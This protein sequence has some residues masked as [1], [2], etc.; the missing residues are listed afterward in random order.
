MSS[1]EEP[2][3]DPECGHDAVLYLLCGRVAAGKSTLAKSLARRHNAVLIG[4]DYCLSLLYSDAIR[5]FQDYIAYSQRLRKLISPHCVE[6]L[7]RGINVVL[8]FP[9]NTPKC[10]QWLKHIVEQAKARH[11]LH[12]V[13]TPKEQC[14]QQL[15]QRI[16]EQGDNASPIGL[17][18]F[19]RIN[20]YFVPPDVAEGFNVEIKR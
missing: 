1:L 4:E 17:K 6:L 10:R 3:D 16:A 2:V 20:Q 7:R 13:A 8:D 5:N 19:E 11:V 14:R 9:A 15:H 18:E 12:Y